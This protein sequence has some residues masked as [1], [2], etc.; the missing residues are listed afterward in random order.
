VRRIWP[1]LLLVAVV[2]FPALAGGLPARR[3]AVVVTATS[4]TDDFTDLTGLES[5][6]V[7]IGRP[8][9]EGVEIAGAGLTLREFRD[10]FSSNT[11][12]SWRLIRNTGNFDYGWHEATQTLHT[13]GRSDVPDG[14]WH[15]LILIRDTCIS[16]S[17]WGIEGRMRA[18]NLPWGVWAR[19]L[20]TLNLGTDTMCYGLA[21]RSWPNTFR[22]VRHLGEIGWTWGASAD[23]NWHRYRFRYDAEAQE[24]RFWRDGVADGTY[25]GITSLEQCVSPVVLIAAAEDT[26]GT[27]NP[28][29]D[30]WWDDIRVLALRAT[31][32]STLIAPPQSGFRWGRVYW[33]G[34]VPAG[35]SIRVDVLDGSTG[36][37]LLSNVSSGRSLAGIDAAAHP[38]LRLQATLRRG[39]DT[40]RPVLDRWR[41][42]WVSP[43][44]TP[45]PT[46]TPTRTPTPTPIHTPTR[47]PTPSRTPTRTPTP[48]NTPTRTPT[49]TNTPTRTP[50][51]TNTFTPTPTN[52]PTPTPT[53]TPTH[54]P[55]N[56]PTPTPTSTPTP[57]PTLT[58]I[59][60]TLSL[61][62]DYPYLICHGPR[63]DPPRPAQTLRGAYSGPAPLG[64]RTVSIEVND[65]EGFTAWYSAV[66]DAA[67]DFILD[68][69]TSG[70]P[71]FGTTST[72][73]W[74][75]VAH[76]WVN[77][78]HY[79][80]LPVFWQ[81]RWFPVHLI[82]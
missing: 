65:G 34:N 76:I 62:R 13:W 31:V 72:G 9:A 57:T 38:T 4:W 17:A 33:T 67:G 23:R 3:A 82:P 59:P 49:P 35:T 27:Y 61:D 73:W 54:T 18:A 47:T 16:G 36:Q 63:L 11:V 7:G 22:V 1:V 74:F 12:G 44:P 56:T 58:P 75:A 25:T 77:G 20:Q 64:G 43:T 37:V 79:A 10:D 78:T 5:N 60:V 71:D 53:Y 32:R 45:T 81:V 70:D 42:T 40:G 2:A 29:V 66:T 26:S 55:T 14:D 50:T 15:E 69:I 80:T 19:R 46:D 21:T 39:F 8:V 6:L 52:T 24:G 28:N 51:P 41:V 68:A 48:T 30:T